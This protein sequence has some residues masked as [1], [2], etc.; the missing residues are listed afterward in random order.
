MLG[1]A[2]WSMFYLRVPVPGNG[3]TMMLTGLAG[4]AVTAIGSWQD[5]GCRYRRLWRVLEV[6]GVLITLPWIVLGL[7][8]LIRLTT[9][10]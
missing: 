5:R 1:I 9:R 8:G 3:L 7:V 10:L 6:V 2:A 4:F